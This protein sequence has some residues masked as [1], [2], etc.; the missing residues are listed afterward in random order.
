MQAFRSWPNARAHLAHCLDNTGTDYTIDLEGLLRDSRQA[1]DLFKD[2]LR[3]AQAFVERLPEGE[4]NITSGAV[5]TQYVTDSKDWYYAVGGYSAW[6]K[7]RAKV[8]CLPDGTKELHLDFE[9]K[10]R[11]RYNWDKGKQV[12]ILGITVTDEC[13]GRLH[14]AG[15][16]KE[17]DMFGSVS[18]SITWRCGQLP[19]AVPP[20]PGG[21]GRR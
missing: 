3:Q 17:F 8:K 20:A 19:P 11:D 15:V 7:G 2:E 12:T 9:Y 6:E 1:R 10:F 4:W 16:A 13:M 18:R 21:G 5:S 14:R